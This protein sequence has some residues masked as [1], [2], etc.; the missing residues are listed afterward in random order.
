MLAIKKVWLQGKFFLYTTRET[1]KL[2]VRLATER[3]LRLYRNNPIRLRSSNPSFEEYPDNIFG[4]C[5]NREKRR[6]KECIKWQHE[7]NTT[8]QKN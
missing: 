6:V 7:H 3:A 5:G 1:K 4:K 2:L 8:T